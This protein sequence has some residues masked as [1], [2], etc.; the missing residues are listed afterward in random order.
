MGEYSLKKCINC[1]WTGQSAKPSVC[2]DC[3]ETY[4]KCPICGNK[5]VEYRER[6]FLFIRSKH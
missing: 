4:Y 6:P 1:Q 5:V 3:R 2:Q